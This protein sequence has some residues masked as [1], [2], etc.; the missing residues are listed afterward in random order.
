[1][2]SWLLGAG[3]KTSPDELR[4]RSI[5][6]VTGALILTALVAFVI[7][8][9]VAIIVTKR[10]AK[11]DALAEAE[12]TA[13]AMSDTMFAP[14]MQSVLNGN[15]SALNHLNSAVVQRHKDGVIVRVKVWNRNGVVLYSD[16]R[17]AIGHRYPLDAAVRQT[18]DHGAS[19]A[20]VSN[21]QQAENVTEAGVANRLIEVYTP[22]TLPTGD[23]FAF[24]LYS[25]DARV[26]SAEHNLMNRIVPL[27]LLSL[28]VLLVLQLPVSVWLVRR[29]ARGSA[30]RAALLGR[31]LSV[32]ENERR[33]IAHDLHDGVVQE[34]AGAGYALS[35]LTSRLP[36][37]TDDSSASLLSRASDA[38]RSSVSS[39]RTLI[40]DIYPPDLSV[41]G[42]QSAITDLAG[43]LAAAGVNVTV[44][45][46]P[47]VQSA[48]VSA[49][50]SAM[51]YRC[52]RECITNISKHAHAAHVWVTLRAI[53]P[54][55]VLSVIDDGVG[56]PATGID[57]R[58]EGHLGLRLLQDAVAE[59]GGRL[60]AATVPTGGTSVIVEL[61]RDGVNRF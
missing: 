8:A 3:R 48:D 42:M 40:V 49:D 53:G 34:L 36:D 55:L 16:D 50:V 18:I 11:D 9:S 22:L 56:L 45:V 61:P 29:V 25:S 54:A 12:R 41:K 17:S 26:R 38:V 33:I 30:E 27:A 39:L 32:S 37:G 7:V 57:R 60:D 59:M 51:L 35:S 1:M 2:R 21:L 10:I 44:E 15:R 28:L 14:V 19:S 46:D 31:V 5:R 6:R 4:R 20:E 43:P 58:A 47:H 52:A 23:R 13:Q 24:E